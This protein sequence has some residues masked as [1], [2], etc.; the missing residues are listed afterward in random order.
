[1]F[2][3]WNM[4]FCCFPPKNPSS[5]KA[6]CLHLYSEGWISVA[7]G[8][9]RCLAAVLTPQSRLQIISTAVSS[10]PQPGAAAWFR[11]GS[12]KETEPRKLHSD[13]TWRPVSLTGWRV[14]PH[15]LIPVSLKEHPPPSLLFWALSCQVAAGWQ[16]YVDTWTLRSHVMAE[17]VNLKPASVYSLSSSV[18]V[19]ASCNMME[20]G[21]Q[22]RKKNSRRP[23]TQAS[24]YFWPHSISL[25]QL[26]RLVR[27]Q[28]C[29]KP[30]TYF[31]FSHSHNSSLYINYKFT[32]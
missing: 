7:S 23:E 17:H 15:L 12:F 13:P 9:V 16:K 25:N 24:T 30:E 2:K 11:C 4:K 18:S 6:A 19:K 22:T 32:F 27:R 29:C 26:Q 14:K 3:N 8:C 21:N 1:M 5:N 28:A 10:C 31:G 20:V